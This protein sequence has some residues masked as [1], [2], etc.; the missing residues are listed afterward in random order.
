MGFKVTQNQPVTQKREGSKLKMSV[1]RDLPENRKQR[2]DINEGEEG[3]LAVVI[4][5]VC[6]I[7]LACALPHTLQ[8]KSKTKYCLAQSHIK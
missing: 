6:W 3:Y 8:K 1:C 5:G 4:I 7:P 2:G